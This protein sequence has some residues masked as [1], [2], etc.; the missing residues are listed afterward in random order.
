MTFQEEVKTLSNVSTKLLQHL[1]REPVYVEKYIEDECE[2]LQKEGW[3][4]QEGSRPRVRIFE[5]EKYT[6]KVAFIHARKGEHLTGADFAFELK[7]KK[8]VFVQSK[9]VNSGKRGKIYFNRFQLQKLIELEGKICNKFSFSAPIY[10]FLLP[11]SSPRVTFYH[12]ILENQGQVEDR[13]FHTSEISFTL[14]GH[15]STSQKEFLNH[16]LKSDDFRRMFWECK[17]GGPDIEED[18]KKDVFYEYSLLTNR[19]IIWLEIEEK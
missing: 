1:E 6:L 19:L 17:I 16:G 2:R 3:F 9:R 5:R 18:I 15:K 8:V 12:L 13:F 10:P 7:D 11:Y 4:E 14:G